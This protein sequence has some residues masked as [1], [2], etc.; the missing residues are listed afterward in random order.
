M[1]SD[2]KWFVVPVTLEGS[3]VSLNVLQGAHKPAGAVE[4]VKAQVDIIRTR[5]ARLEVGDA[6]P[7]AEFE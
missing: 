1:T 2:L 3:Y 5:G 6:I 7:I 4:T